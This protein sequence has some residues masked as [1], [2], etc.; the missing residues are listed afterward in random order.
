MDP[1]EKYKEKF[2]EYPPLMF[3][4]HVDADALGEA[5]VKA[6]N[7]GKELWTYYYDQDPAEKAAIDY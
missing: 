6:V 4:R 3:F 7:E 5:I 2:G 1:M